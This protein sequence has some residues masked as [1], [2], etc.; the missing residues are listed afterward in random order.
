MRTIKKNIGRATPNIVKL[1]M[2]SVFKFSALPASSRLLAEFA[3]GFITALGHARLI[4]TFAAKAVELEGINRANDKRSGPAPN[5]NV[6]AIM[7]PKKVGNTKS[8]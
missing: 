7:S 4:A 3:I 8:Q 6:K 1:L 5:Q 2:I